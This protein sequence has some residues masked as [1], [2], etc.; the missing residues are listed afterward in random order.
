MHLGLQMSQAA[1]GIP[2]W[3]MLAAN[4][5]Q[6]IADIVERCCRLSQRFAAD[7]QAAGAQ[8][9]APVVLN[10]VLVHFD[11]DAVTDAVI[12]TTAAGGRCWMG[13]TTWQGRRAMRVSVSDVATTE[14]DIDIAAEA[15]IARLGKGSDPPRTSRIRLIGCARVARQY[16]S[17]L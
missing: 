13:G 2:V 7:V 15:V 14:A 3:A 11:D 4:G 17:P 10:Q 12:A 6:G 1:R 8:V 9:L 16:A 5:R